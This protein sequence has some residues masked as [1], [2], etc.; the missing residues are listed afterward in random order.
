VYPAVDYLDQGVPSSAETISYWVEPD[1]A[2][3][4]AGQYVLYRSVNGGP[5]AVVSAGLLVD[6]DEPVFSYERLDGD[7]K[8]VPI[9]RGDLPLYHSAPTHGSAADTGTFASVDSIRV[10]NVRLTGQFV[11]RD[12]RRITRTVTGSTRLLNAGMIRNSVCG[13]TP[14][15]PV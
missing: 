10:V 11:D 13:D 6:D 15:S 1:S 3:S 2:P 12:G 4:R 8:L 7:G 14:L 5:R 9:S